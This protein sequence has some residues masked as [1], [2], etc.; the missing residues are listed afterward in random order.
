MRWPLDGIHERQQA[1]SVD[2]AND[3]GGWARFIRGLAVQRR[4]LVALIIRQLMTKYGRNNIGFLWI[5]LEP[6]ILCSGV[7]V[8]RSLISNS[9]ENGVPLV[10]VLTTGYLPLTLWRHLTNAGVMILRRSGSMLYHR[11]ISLIDC[12]IATIVLETSGCTLAGTIVY[13]TLYSAGLMGPIY[14]M[15]LVLGG[16]LLMALLATGLLFVFAVLTEYYEA[17]ERFIQPWQYLMI[18]LCGFFFMVNW[19]PSYAQK[20]AWYMPTIH[21]YEMIRAG[22]FGPGIPTYYT[23][24]YP[25]LWGIG[26]MAWALPRIEKARDKIH[27]G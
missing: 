17:T 5:V 7:L 24:W 11:D 22:A 3:I 20:L 14:D 8:I 13:W 1:M 4:I 25:A 21:C 19:L 2:I 26:M 18:P 15:G 6:M 12:C 23:P 9:E 16:W 27:F 10:A